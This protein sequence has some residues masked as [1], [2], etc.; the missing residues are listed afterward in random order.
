MG[1][2]II[3]VRCQPSDSSA[4]LGQW[5]RRPPFESQQT[6]SF[7]WSGFVGG[8]DDDA[9]VSDHRRRSV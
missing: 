8:W 2:V 5:I 7:Y 3:V 4:R 1:V 9:Q 6:R